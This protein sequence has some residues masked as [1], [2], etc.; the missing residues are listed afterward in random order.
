MNKVI[1]IYKSISNILFYTLVMFLIIYCINIFVVKYIY[2][3]DFPRVFNYY[4]FNVAS[5][6]MEELL[7]KGDYI[8]VEKTS[9]FDVGDVVTFHKNNYFITH[10]VIKIEGDTI[11]TKGD[12]NSIQDAEISRSDIVGKFVCKS[13]IIA[14]LIKYKVFIIGFIIISY[15]IEFLLDLFKQ[16][17]FN[18]N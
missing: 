16:K 2:R 4:V 7:H 5:G 1:K 13:T 18:K 15:I 14:F 10:R 11:T 17:Q 9:D 6:S 3:E 12:A 8:I